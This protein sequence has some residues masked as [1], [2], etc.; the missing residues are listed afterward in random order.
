[1]E[2]SWGTVLA[3]YLPTAEKGCAAENAD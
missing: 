3:T 2:H 1:M